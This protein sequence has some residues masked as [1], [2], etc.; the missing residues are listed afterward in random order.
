MPATNVAKIYL[1]L[2]DGPKDDPASYLVT[3]VVQD[4]RMRDA[5]IACIRICPM[6]SQLYHA[7]EGK[8]GVRKDNGFLYMSRGLY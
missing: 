6:W 1:D 4:D 2:D 3:H 5:Y 7:P 8:K